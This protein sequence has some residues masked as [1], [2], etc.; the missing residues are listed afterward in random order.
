[1]QANVNDGTFGAL[2]VTVIIGAVLHLAFCYKKYGRADAK[3][4]PEKIE[5]R[6]G[7]EDTE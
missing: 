2:F 1:M 7:R 6:E 3:D 4:N 5:N